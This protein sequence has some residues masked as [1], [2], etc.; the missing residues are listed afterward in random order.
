MLEQEKNNQTP[1]VTH[2]Q[3]Y[4]FDVEAVDDFF[5]KQIST[6]AFAKKIRRYLRESSLI[7]LEN[8]NDVPNDLSTTMAILDTFAEI[9][10][11]YFT[12]LD[13]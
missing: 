13:Y 9:L 8:P 12:K 1:A 4:C 2:R 11:P 7:Y 5:R 3:A 6:Q 10:D